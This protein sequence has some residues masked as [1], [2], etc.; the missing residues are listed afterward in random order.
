MNIIERITSVF[1]ERVV[2]LDC[3]SVISS[4]EYMRHPYDWSYRGGIVSAIANYRPKRVYVVSN[5][6][7]IILG[8]IGEE[9]AKDRYEK[10]MSTIYETTGAHV[11]YMFCKSPCE[12]NILRLPNTGM[13]EYLA[14]EHLESVFNPSKIMFVYSSKEAR[15]CAERLGCKSMGVGDFIEKYAK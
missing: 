13:V 12:D 8:C 7:S 6:D 5:E 1:S 9:D 11:G 14:H 10:I 2:F 4:G 3:G 15:E